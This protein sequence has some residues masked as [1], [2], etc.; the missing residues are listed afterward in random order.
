MDEFKA[1]PELRVALGLARL[2]G[3]FLMEK[4]GRADP[5]FRALGGAARDDADSVIVGGGLA[6]ISDEGQARAREG[7]ER[8]RERLGGGSW[9]S[10]DERQEGRSE[11]VNEIARGGRN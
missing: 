3:D 8:L 2:L 1:S 10:I 4:L 9:R 7:L 11:V 5:R 6:G